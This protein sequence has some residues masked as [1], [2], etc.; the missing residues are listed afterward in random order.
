MLLALIFLSHILLHIDGPRASPFPHHILIFILD[1][2]LTVEHEPWGVHTGLLPWWC[3]QMQARRK[4]P[5]AQTLTPACL[6]NHVVSAFLSS[7]FFVVALSLFKWCLLWKVLKPRQRTE[8]DVTPAAVF[9]AQTSRCCR[10]DP[11]S[12][13]CVYSGVLP[14]LSV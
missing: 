4:P 7:L 11:S 14:E 6:E 1:K 5:A 9:T 10:Q 12:G 13:H 3:W 8:S 2:R